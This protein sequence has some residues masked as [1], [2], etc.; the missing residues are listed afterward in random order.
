MRA[1][2]IVLKEEKSIWT[3]LLKETHEKTFISENLLILNVLHS[4]VDII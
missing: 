3:S 4:L 2:Q 1:V